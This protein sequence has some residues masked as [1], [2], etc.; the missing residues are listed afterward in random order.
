MIYHK[1]LNDQYEDKGASVNWHPPAAGPIHFHTALALYSFCC[2]LLF[3]KI[4]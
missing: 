2:V 1:D 4:I 3:D